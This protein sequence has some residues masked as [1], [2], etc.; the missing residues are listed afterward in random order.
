VQP[1][2]ADEP[3]REPERDGKTPTDARTA[4]SEELLQ[5]SRMLRIVHGN[6]TYRLMLT[7]NNKLILQK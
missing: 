2:S 1:R 4:T 7:R 6:E 5:G 3:E